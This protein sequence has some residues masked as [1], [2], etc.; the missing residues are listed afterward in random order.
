[1]RPRD[2]VIG[3]DYLC[4]VISLEGA[5]GII[6]LFQ[7]SSYIEWE[8]EFRNKKGR[9]V[10][11]THRIFL[12]MPLM[13]K[14]KGPMIALIAVTPWQAKLPFYA[15]KIWTSFRKLDE[16]EKVFAMVAMFHMMG[17]CHKDIKSLVD[18]LH[19]YETELN[20]LLH[21]AAMGTS[22]SDIARRME[23][24]DQGSRFA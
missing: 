7:V 24:F 23:H 8:I 6:L 20:Q 11:E 1:G 10:R 9:T 17:F 16:V 2:E 22:D 5:G 3:F 18:L 15:M 13:Q 21:R 19:D 14:L 4:S 12:S